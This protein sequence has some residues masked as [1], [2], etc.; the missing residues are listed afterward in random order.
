MS[1]NNE[2]NFARPDTVTPSQKINEEYHLVKHLGDSLVA[3][4]EDAN[5]ERYKDRKKSL[6][7]GRV[8]HPMAPV[9][10]DRGCERSLYY[11]FK[12]YPSDR[13]FPDH[14]YRI[15]EMGH[16]G[17]DLVV[18]NIRLA[19]F[20]ILTHDEKGNQFGFGH[21]HDPDTGQPQ[22]KGFIDGVITDGPEFIGTGKDDGIKMKYPMLWENKMVNDAKFKKFKNEGVERSHP[23]YYGQM[24]AYMNFMHLHENPGLLT[25]VNR[26]TGDIAIEFVRFNQKHTHAII[27]R[28]SRIIE[29]QGPLTLERAAKD[30]E[31]LPCKWCDF[32]SHCKKDEENRAQSND[33]Q[34][35][36]APSW[37]GGGQK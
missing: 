21:A 30:W 7:A 20:T 23:Q 1:N 26:N 28:A 37:L 13:P 12:Q 27:Q 3:A 33:G 14:L 11:E 15:F 8:G 10:W 29:A 6:G 4:R 2:M 16:Q 34:P 18:E 32:K 25:M 5:K 36:E 17:E 31:K 9:P 22:Y 24:Q 19:G 35:T